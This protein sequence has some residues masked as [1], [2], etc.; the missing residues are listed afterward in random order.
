MGVLV[1]MIMSMAGFMLVL[2]FGLELVGVGLLMGV[3][4]VILFG[5]LCAFVDVNFC[6]RD[7]ATVDLFYLERCVDIQRAYGLTEDSGIDSGVDEGSEEHI[8]ANTGEAIEIGDTHGVIVS[9]GTDGRDGEES[10]IH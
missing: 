2:R 9:R 10:L 1:G 8:A 6:R 4:F 5:K 3:M 7:S